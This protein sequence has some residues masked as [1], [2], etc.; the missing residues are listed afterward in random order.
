MN[1]TTQ[2]VSLTGVGVSPTLT[3][4]PST[5]TFTSQL[6]GTRSADQTLTVT[7]TGSVVL[8]FSG[9]NVSGNFVIDAAATTCST[10]STVAPSATCQV[11]VAFAPASTGTLTG[12]LVLTDNGVGSPQTVSLTGTGVAPVSSLFPSSLSFGNQLVGTTSAAQTGIVTNTGT[13]NLTVSNVGLTG[14]NGGDFAK[15]ADTC[16]GATVA[17]SATCTASVTFKPAATGSRSASLAFTDNA[18]NSPQ[19]VALSG[20]GIAPAVSFS[21]TTVNFGSQIL[22]T[23]SGPQTLTVTNSGSTNLAI[24]TVSNAGT[25]ASDFTKQSDSCSGAT[26]APS[27]NC[28]VALV[29]KP[30]VAGDESATLSVADN[31]SNSPQSVAL[32]GMGADFSFTPASGSSTSA[33]VSAGGTA[34]YTL[35][36]N[37]L[38][39]FTQTV[40][41][42]CTDPVPAS[43]C[44]LNPTSLTPG[45]TSA[46]TV[47]VSVTTTARGM[48]FRRP[49]APPQFGPFGLAWWTLILMAGALALLSRAVGRRRLGVLLA[50]TLLVLIAFAA[51]GGGG[52]TSGPRPP[53]GTTAGNY[54]ITVTGTSQGL[55]HSIQLTLTVF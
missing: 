37:S 28:S 32:T 15:S 20:T 47:T 45:G 44:T 12:S 10:S 14:A 48:A 29:F 26:V 39:G 30:S 42:T 11:A 18:S 17:P 23:T 13:G 31:A 34:T 52:G 50:A 6:V 5:L 51:C 40:N 22:A 9:I 19:A 7:N 3:L 35:S 54:V 27:S 8:S 1:G 36:F 38:G 25:N 33:T 41:L 55:T 24:S 43:T 53:T 49:P 2:T 4:S 21:P 16:T 46:P